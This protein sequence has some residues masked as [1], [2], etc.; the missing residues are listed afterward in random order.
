MK[1]LIFLE[2]QDNN[3]ILDAPAMT[4]HIQETCEDVKY[5]TEFG[6]S[7]GV[8]PSSHG[9]AAPSASG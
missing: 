6:A 3:D 8:L 1:V 7:L 2:A 5:D 4:L 9:T